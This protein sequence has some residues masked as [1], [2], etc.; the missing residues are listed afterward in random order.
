MNTQNIKSKI[1]SIETQLKVLSSKKTYQKS[2]SKSGTL[3]DLKGCLKGKGNFSEKEIES[4]EITFSDE[5]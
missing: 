1:I 4:S 5:L 2:D 3:V